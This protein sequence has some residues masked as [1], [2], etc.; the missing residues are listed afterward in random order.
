M[1]VGREDQRTGPEQ[2][3]APTSGEGEPVIDQYPGGTGFRMSFRMTF[4]EQVRRICENDARQARDHAESARG[5]NLAR[6]ALE[7][8]WKKVTVAIVQS[9]IPPDAHVPTP[10]GIVRGNEAYRRGPHDTTG[11]FLGEPWIRRVSQRERRARD[12]AVLNAMSSSVQ[13][14]WDMKSYIYGDGMHNRNSHIGNER[15]TEKLF[16]AQ[17]S[18]IYRSSVVERWHYPSVYV[19]GYDWYYPISTCMA[20]GDDV[21]GVLE[22]A[23]ATLVARR[24]L[25]LK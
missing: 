23:L 18:T 4:D 11:S 6:T 8:T 21:A 3:N 17:D 2:R 12:E 13:Q 1:R 10:E 7:E 9:G 25:Q 22:T 5:R 24:R 20:L 19:S 14:A 15:G 16:L